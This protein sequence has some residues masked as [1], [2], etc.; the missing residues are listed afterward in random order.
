MAWKADRFLMA[1]QWPQQRTALDEMYDQLEWTVMEAQMSQAER[2]YDIWLYWHESR[3]MIVGAGSSMRNWY[4]LCRES[5][6]DAISR[7]QVGP[8]QNI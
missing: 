3:V 5:W 7:F 8:I 1:S 2:A 4:P 6:G